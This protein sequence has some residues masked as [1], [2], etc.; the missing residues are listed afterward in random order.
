VAISSE[1]SRVVPFQIAIGIFSGDFSFSFATADFS[2]E[3]FSK[4]V[5][6]T[7][8]LLKKTHKV[9]YQI[10]SQSKNSV[11]VSD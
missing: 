5:R 4:S 7:N 1:E 8:L 9:S 10:G 6:F 2:E 11:Q 3:I